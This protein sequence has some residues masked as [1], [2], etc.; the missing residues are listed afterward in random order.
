MCM[1]A[2]LL[3]M[4]GFDGAAFFQLAEYRQHLFPIAEALMR[5]QLQFQRG[6]VVG[7][8]FFQ[9]LQSAQGRCVQALVQ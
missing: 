8:D 7:F 6:D 1:V 5:F 3:Q 4:D 9:L 2:N